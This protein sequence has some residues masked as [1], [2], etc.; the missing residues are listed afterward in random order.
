MILDVSD[1]NPKFSNV[2]E[3]SQRAER[4]H[5]P[6]LQNI[7]SRLPSE[8]FPRGKTVGKVSWLIY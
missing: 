4:E 2:A 8:Q 1:T 7:L 3:S 5:V 6:G